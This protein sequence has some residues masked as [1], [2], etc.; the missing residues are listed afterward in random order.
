MIKK[1]LIVIVAI[2]A[3]ILIGG[4]L[5]PS[6][7]HVERSIIINKPASQVYNFINDFNNFNKYSPWYDQDTTTPFKI[8]A[9]SSGV[10]AKY[11]WN[12]EKNSEIGMGSLTTTNVV[13]NEKIE[14]ELIFG[15]SGEPQKV[16]YLMSQENEGTKV[17]WFMD[18]N[19]GL[20]P[21]MRYM[22]AIFFKGMME[23]A[24]DKGL[25]KMK[26][27]LENQK[28]TSDFPISEVTLQPKFYVMLKAEATS[29]NIGKVLENSFEI[30]S[31]S[32]NEEEITGPPI[33]RYFDFSMD[34][35]FT[36]SAGMPVADTNTFP[37]K[38]GLKYETIQGKHVALEYKGAYDKMMPAY[39]A[40]QQYI[41]KMGLKVM[42]APFEEYVSDPMT[43]KDTSNWLTNIYFPVQ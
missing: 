37:L 34:K 7:K 42:N 29:D 20:N 6:T 40:L 10:G 19:F 22:G 23:E 2:V 25:T 1:I 38:G 12:N 39:D 35:P 13:A 21:L 8:S 5:L 36:L 31:K 43:E 32:I 28:A 9:K 14:Q 33:A 11:E 30:I 24:Y 4:F 3:L 26:K 41:D 15:A 16:G 27:V 17:T 18:A